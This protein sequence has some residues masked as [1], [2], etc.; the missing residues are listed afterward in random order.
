MRNPKG[1]SALIDDPPLFTPPAQLLPFVLSV[2]QRQ[3][4]QPAMIWNLGSIHGMATTRRI[5][6][7][8][9]ALQ[10]IFPEKPPVC[11]SISMFRRNPRDNVNVGGF[12]PLQF[13]PIDERDTDNPS[14]FTEPFPSRPPFLRAHNS[15]RGQRDLERHP[16]DHLMRHTKPTQPTRRSSR[17]TLDFAPYF[18]IQT[19]RFSRRNLDIWNQLKTMRIYGHPARMHM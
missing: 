19:G 6:L 1:K 15:V 12:A 8:V 3:I 17:K 16:P 13:D 2:V 18:S 4:D 7:L 9:D 14:T 11:R 5:I 10:P